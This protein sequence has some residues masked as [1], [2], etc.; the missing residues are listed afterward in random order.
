[1]KEIFQSING[2]HSGVG[3][4]TSHMAAKGCGRR[5]VTLAGIYTYTKAMYNPHVGLLG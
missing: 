1:M 4:N 5:C 3:L 2:L